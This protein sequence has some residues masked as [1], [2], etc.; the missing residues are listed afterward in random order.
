MDKEVAIRVWRSML[1]PGLR[2]QRHEPTVKRWEGK[3]R[4][5]KVV[6]QTPPPPLKSVTPC[7]QHKHKHKTQQTSTRKSTSGE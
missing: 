6:K 2:D 5:N 3:T 7:H 4:A 1:A